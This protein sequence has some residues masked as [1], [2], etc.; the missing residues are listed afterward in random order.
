MKR[1]ISVIMVLL[2]TVMLTSSISGI[3]I[4]EPS[5]DLNVKSAILMDANTG[6]VLYSQNENQPLFTNSLW[7]ILIFV[8]IMMHNNTIKA[9]R[10]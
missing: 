6:T 3:E 4:K 1:I 5:L 2:F 9:E 10:K 8:K 7:K